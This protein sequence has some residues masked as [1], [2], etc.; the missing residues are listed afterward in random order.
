MKFKLNL[1]GFGFLVLI[2]IVVNQSIMSEVD[3]FT[4]K[5]IGFM[6]ISNGQFTYRTVWSLTMTA[7]YTSQISIT[8]WFK[9]FL[10]MEIISK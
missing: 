3:N 2:I 6:V 1:I 9:N 7:T 10:Q 4:I 8:M 5:R